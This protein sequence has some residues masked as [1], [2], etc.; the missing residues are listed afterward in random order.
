ME[1]LS[2][3]LTGLCSMTPDEQAKGWAHSCQDAGLDPWRV[4]HQQSYGEGQ[5]CTGCKNLASRYESL[6]RTRRRF[7]WR[8]E[9]HYQMFE[10]YQGGER[11][12]IAPLECKDWE[13][14]PLPK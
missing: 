13:R 1:E 2:D 10:H 6:P 7:F 9:L 5:E 11:V 3:L 4:V 14:R 8:C 12:L